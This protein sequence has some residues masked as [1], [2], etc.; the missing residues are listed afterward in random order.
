M[1]A[2]E[3]GNID[4]VKLLLQAGADKN[5]QNK[6]RNSYGIII[7]V[8]MLDCMLYILVCYCIYRK[9]KLHWFWPA[10]LI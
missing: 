4:I 7:Y 10:Q 8:V 5:I 9:V 2:S 3:K 6:V 1:Y